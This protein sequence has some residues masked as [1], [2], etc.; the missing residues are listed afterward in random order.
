MCHI[1]FVFLSV[2]FYSSN[3]GKSEKKERDKEKKARA[4]SMKR[5]FKLSIIS[6]DHDEIV[7][8]A[9]EAQH[10]KRVTFKFSLMDDDPQEIVQNM[11]GFYACSVNHWNMLLFIT[12][13]SSK[14]TVLFTLVNFQLK[15]N[16]SMLQCSFTA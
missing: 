10:G 3:E 13:F 6:V 7:E 4:K 12:A 16:P 11:V 14:Q 5:K 8:C 15:Q 9:F 1:N 2:W